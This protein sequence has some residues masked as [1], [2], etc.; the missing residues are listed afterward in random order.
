MKQHLLSEEPEENEFVELYEHHRFVVDKGQGMVRIDKYLANVMGGT[1]RNRIQEA[2]AEGQILVND[3]AVKSNYRIK[4]NESISIV[5]DYPKNE[6]TIVPQEIPLDIVYEADHLM[7][8]NNQPILV[9]HPGSGNFDGTLL[10]G[11][12]WHL[13]SLSGFDATNPL[14]GLVHRIEKDT[15]G[16]LIFGPSDWAQC[17]LCLLVF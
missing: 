12:A 3:K 16:L 5:L 7:V 6:M 10:N 2:A 1:S 4:P 11:V 9:V 13:K 15:A 14:I 8:V 17:A